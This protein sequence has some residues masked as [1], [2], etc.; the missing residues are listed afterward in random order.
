VRG[1]HRAASV[2]LQSVRCIGYTD[3]TMDWRAYEADSAH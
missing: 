1:A 3:H 2:G